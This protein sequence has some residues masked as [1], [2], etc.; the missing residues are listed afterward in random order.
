[1]SYYCTLAD[2]KA[3]LN[4]TSTVDDSLLLTLIGQVSAR[5]DLL[6][7]SSTS[8]FAPWTETREFEISYENVDSNRNVFLLPSGETLLSLTSL[9]LAGSAVSGVEAYPALRVPIKMIRRTD[10]CSW[11]ENGT[12]DPLTTVITGVWGYHRAY[13]RAWQVVDALA[14]A[15]VSTTAT[16]L[17][18]ADADG[19]DLYGF[20]PR[21]SAGNLIKIDSELMEVTA[22]NTTTN[23]LNVRRGVNG[24]TAAT[25]LIAAAV[26]TWQTD[27]NIRRVTA[28]QAGL[29][30][31]RRGAYEQ[32]Q[33][34]DIGVITYPADLLM[35]LRGVLQGFQYL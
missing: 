22:T 20:T 18:V 28:R 1:M 29:L 19:A 9:T 26:S 30:Y 31:A 21:L 8:Y 34:T 32:Q 23:V 6:M 27:D 33:I 17:T 13:A 14:A 24:T 7:A 3:A 25:H 15:I 2:A 35:E 4:A 12:D 11:Y 10:G 5:I 16:T